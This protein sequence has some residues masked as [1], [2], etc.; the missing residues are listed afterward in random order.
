MLQSE[1]YDFGIANV[2]EDWFFGRPDAADRLN[3]ACNRLAAIAKAS[4]KPVAVVLGPTETVNPEHRGA[5]DTVRDSFAAQGIAVFP[6]VERAAWMMAQL[7][8]HSIGG[9]N[10]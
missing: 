7:Y 4:A 1:A 6:S 2:G 10:L 9:K 5:V 8:T 3:H